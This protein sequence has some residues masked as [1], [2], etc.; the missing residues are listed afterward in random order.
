MKRQ[1]VGESSPKGALYPQHA[2]PS[3]GPPDSREQD[4]ITVL[5]ALAP[6]LLPRRGQPGRQ[7]CSRGWRHRGQASSAPLQPPPRGI[8]KPGGHLRQGLVSGR[9]SR[10]G[11]GSEQRGGT[12]CGSSLV[13]R[14]LEWLRP[15]PR[16]RSWDASGPPGMR[17]F[18]R[19]K[20]LTVQLPRAGCDGGSH[21][22]W[23][24]T[25]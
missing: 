11:P 24:D 1:G 2:G 25:T 8:C 17:L 7:R 19:A 9:G 14:R 21:T 16:A 3:A 20:G 4:S 6:G 12:R 23:H 15:L 5:L 22:T 18:Y 13:G 10:C